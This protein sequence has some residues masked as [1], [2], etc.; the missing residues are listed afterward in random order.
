MLGL[1]RGL[2]LSVLALAFAQSAIAQRFDISVAVEVDS[3]EANGQS[4]VI[5]RDRFKALVVQA[6]QKHFNSVAPFAIDSRANTFIVAKMYYW[7]KGQTHGRFQASKGR[8]CIQLYSEF[9]GSD[10]IGDDNCESNFKKSLSRALKD[11]INYAGPT[12]REIEQTGTYY[13]WLDYIDTGKLRSKDGAPVSYTYGESY[14]PLKSTREEM[15][16]GSLD[17]GNRQHELARTA[18]K[19]VRTIIARYFQ[20]HSSGGPELHVFNSTDILFPVLSSERNIEKHKELI[21]DLINSAPNRYR[22][23][24]QLMHQAIAGKAPRSVIETILEK[25]DNCDDFRDSL[26]ATP[27][28]RAM[29][30]SRYDLAQLFIDQ[31]CSIAA[32]NAVG[33]QV[34]HVATMASVMGGDFS[35]ID[36]AINNGADINSVAGEGFTPLGT[37][38]YANKLSEKPIIGDR[39]V[40]GFLARG[41]HIENFSEDGAPLLSAL[42]IAV[43][44]GDANIVKALLD[45]GTN[46]NPY[47][48]KLPS[49]VQ[50]A[51]EEGKP[52]ILELL[53]EAGADPD[54]TTSVNKTRALNAAYPDPSQAISSN[55]RRLIDLLL[56]YGADSTYKDASGY[57]AYQR[58]EGRRRAYLAE[59]ARLAEQRAREEEERRQRAAEAERRRRLQARQRRDDWFDTA[60]TILQGVTLGLNEYN[61]QV[62]RE[63]YLAE[64]RQRDAFLRQQNSRSYPSSSSSSSNSS[65]SS[66][67]S[68]GGSG[69]I[70]ITVTKDDSVDAQR[71]AERQEAIRRQ[72]E[73]RER[74]NAEAQREREAREAERAA[75]RARREREF[76]A[77]APAHCKAYYANLGKPCPQGQSCVTPE[78]C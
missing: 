19:N 47:L 64:Q 25:R 6:A 62:Q 60:A 74:R 9:A 14:D 26:Q 52:H 53:L 27:L 3:I 17:F 77:N 1:S 4:G 22:L 72:N 51:V 69:N 12:Y 23:W 56:D 20:D 29:A 38:I 57:T 43:S 49:I 71:E 7:P 67:R 33:H 30:Q 45:A 13:D 58:Y 2:L 24:P 16:L 42:Q 73:E 61:A 50:M 55:E 36:L 65:S 21:P 8:V 76:R 78:D 41:S 10:A 35:F 5:D 59:Q 15:G 66:S 31:G 11:L 48:D 68:S 34:V 44:S 37:A 54:A 46:P 75:E 28:I 39:L 32:E 40:A 63:Q 70:T 18:R